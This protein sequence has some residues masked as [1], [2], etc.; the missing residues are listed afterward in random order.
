MSFYQTQ[1]PTRFTPQNPNVVSTQHIQYL[2]SGFNQAYPV[3]VS[4]D[5]VTYTPESLVVNRFITRVGL[6]G[7]SSDVTPTAA[8]IIEALNK[9]QWIRQTSQDSNPIT[10]QPG[11]YVDF[12]IYNEGDYTLNVYPGTGVSIGAATDLYVDSGK[13]VDCRLHV[14]NIASGSEEVY[15]S[16]LTNLPPLI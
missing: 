4:G 3:E 7:V 11:F 16:V 8:Q 12:C 13:L 1:N 14:T 15:I 10:V 9:D 2:R 6:T 5:D